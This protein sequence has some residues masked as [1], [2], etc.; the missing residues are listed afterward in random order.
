MRAR[1]VALVFGVCLL[2]PLS[3]AGRMVSE[4]GGRAVSQQGRSS[5]APVAVGAGLGSG[6]VLRAAAGHSAATQSV[7]LPA[8]VSTAQIVRIP[9]APGPSGPVVVS[10]LMMSVQAGTGRK[11]CYD[12]FYYNSD[13]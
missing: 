11:Y 1:R 5:W 10:G 6:A 8:V 3:L 2:A 9:V 4:A 7:A 12:A 13:A